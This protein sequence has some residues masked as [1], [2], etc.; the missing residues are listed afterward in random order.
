MANW[1]LYALGRCQKRD[2]WII[3][4]YRRIGEPY[5]TIKIR[6]VKTLAQNKEKINLL[7]EP[8]YL[9]NEHTDQKQERLR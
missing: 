6:K 8:S 3:C 1:T 9:A 5:N 7:S 2:G 4:I